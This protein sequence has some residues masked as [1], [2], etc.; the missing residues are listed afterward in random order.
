MYFKDWIFGPDYPN[1]DRQRR[2][3]DALDLAG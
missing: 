3:R 2:A 1:T